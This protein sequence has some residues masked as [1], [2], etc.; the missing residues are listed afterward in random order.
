MSTYI[1]DYTRPDGRTNFS[2]VQANSEAQ[3]AEIFRNRGVDGWTGY[4]YKEYK[5][6]AITKR[7]ER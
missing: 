5:I 6:D 4:N 2:T 1:I 7:H 3:A